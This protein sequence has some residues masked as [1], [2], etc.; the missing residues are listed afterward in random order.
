MPVPV[1]MI[2]VHKTISPSLPFPQLS[3]PIFGCAILSLKA[4]KI[5]VGDDAVLQAP[6][7]G[8]AAESGG[9][10]ARLAVTLHELK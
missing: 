3:N 9:R 5:I 7:S 6:K 8:N 10:A 4:G 1:G 2:H